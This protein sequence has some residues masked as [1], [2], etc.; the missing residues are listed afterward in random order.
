MQGVGSTHELVEYEKQTGKQSL[1]TNSLFS[2]MPSIMIHTRYPGNLIA[3]VNNFISL[4]LPRVADMIFLSLV[5]FYILLTVYGVRPVLAAAGAFAFA[6]STYT[7]VSIEAGHYSKVTAMA[8]MPV[9][10]AGVVLAYRKNIGWGCLLMAVG[11]ALNLISNHVQVTFYTFLAVAIFVISEAIYSFKQKEVR[12]FFIASAGLAVA[13]I[14]AVGTHA[15]YLMSVAEYGAYS[16][17]G[18][19]ELKPKDGSVVS[20]GLDKDYAFDWSYTPAETMTLLIPRFYGGS[21]NENLGKGS[22]TYK[23]LTSKGVPAQSALDFTKSLPTYWGQL[24][25]TSGP[26][27]IGS[28]IIFLF[29]LG[30]L[31]MDGRTKYWLLGVTILSL[32][33]TWGKNFDVFNYFLFDHVPMFNKFRA[34]MMAIII[35]QFSMPVLALVTLERILRLNENKED[36][37]KKLF[38]ALGITAG[39]C[40]IV[41]VIA[42]TF[43]FTSPG[44]VK[45]LESF[46][47]MTGDA[48]FAQQ[49][50]DSIL[51]DRE[52]LMRGDALR[53]M[54]FILL[55]GGLI[56]L[57]ITNKIKETIVVAG[58]ALLIFVDLWALDKNYLNASNFQKKVNDS[59]FGM[60]LADES[61]KRDTALNYRV[62]NLSG[63]PFVE[64]KTSYHHHSIGGNN[65]AKLRRYQ[66]LIERHLS[67]NNEK[68]LNMLNAKYAI[69]SPEQ[70]PQLIPGAL[71][72]AW[73]VSEIKK[74]NSP[75]EEIDALGKF[76]PGLTAVVDI[77]K[78][79]ITKDKFDTS[80]AS[81]SLKEM[82]PDY[83]KYVSNSSAEKLAVF[84]EIYYPVGWTATIDGKPADIIRANYVLRAMYIPAG[85]HTIEMKFDI[86][87][88]HTGNSISLICSILLLGGAFGIVVYEFRKS[89]KS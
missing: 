32:F 41:F 9:V 36:L 76:E 42:G 73:F 4:K 52:G 77:S 89:K 28:I 23:T 45:M 81:I 24:P 10:I 17:R 2:G 29:V 22:E 66:D 27:Y 65:P 38:I 33:L 18:K 55:S 14:I 72:N 86:P 34:V 80:L 56:Y 62:L 21:S 46:K 64:N 44:D 51:S 12:R 78:F 7:I 79:K 47:T 67:T 49:I 84:S 15:G 59:Y 58:I 5:G 88:Y 53:S 19:S 75:D 71:G 25:F 61:I 26:L 63:N 30:L 3:Y 11:L 39:V 35:A 85:T 57:F 6:F 74:V 1:W 82:K 40:A 83:L 50:M 37:K 54:M 87:S 13:A 8:F 60:S 43:D 20:D 31:I 68:V 69:I 70:P 48:G 16:I